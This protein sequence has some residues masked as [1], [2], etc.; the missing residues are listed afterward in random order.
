MLLSANAT[1]TICHSQTDGLSKFCSSADIL[2]AAVGKARFVTKDFV[3]PGAI[4]I[5]VGINREMKGEKS[6]VVG[7][8][9]AESVMG[10]ASLLTPV[11]NGV[12]PMTIAMLIRNTLRAAK[13]RSH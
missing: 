10:I 9:D 2:V 13:N 12:G 11:P 7:D 8:V 6:V 4:V 5:D 1:V 3:K